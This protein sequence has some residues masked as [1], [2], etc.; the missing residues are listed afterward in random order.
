MSDCVLT[1][2]S[3]GEFFN[4]ATRKMKLAA[5]DVEPFIE[6]WRRV[7]PVHAATAD[8]LAAAIG[9]VRRYRLSFWDAMLCATASE[10]GCGLLFSEDLQDG[11]TIGRLRCVNPFAPSNALLIDTLLPAA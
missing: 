2:Q 7:Y 4:V 1:L 11:Q 9:I 3:L 6:D 5:R 10:A 8:C